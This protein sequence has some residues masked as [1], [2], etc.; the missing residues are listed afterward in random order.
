M[1]SC[2][3]GV[4]APGRT[5]NGCSSTYQLTVVLCSSAGYEG[6]ITKR[7]GVVDMMYF[8]LTLDVLRA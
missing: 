5:I 1:F 3:S 4:T 7:V 8:K 2:T 6:I